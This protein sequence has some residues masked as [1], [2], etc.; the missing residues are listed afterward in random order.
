MPSLQQVA[1]DIRRMIQ[2]HG[3]PADVRLRD[4]TT[5]RLSVVDGRDRSQPLTDGLDQGL[6][7]LRFSATDWDT[8]SP[9]R[10]PQKGDQFTL[11]GQRFAVQALARERGFDKPILYAVDVKG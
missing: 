5:F 4:G 2:T 3:T 10:P 8:A 6:R 11:R 1:S 9:G 7:T